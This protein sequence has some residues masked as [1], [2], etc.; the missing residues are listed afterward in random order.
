MTRTHN[1]QTETLTKNIRICKHKITSS[2]RTALVQWQAASSEDIEHCKPCLE[3]HLTAYAR[4]IDCSDS[5]FDIFRVYSRAKDFFSLLDVPLLP[6]QYSS[7]NLGVY[8]RAIGF[9]KIAVRVTL[10]GAKR[11]S[12][13]RCRLRSCNRSSSKTFLEVL[14]I[15]TNSFTTSWSL[16]KC[17]P[18]SRYSHSHSSVIMDMIDVCERLFKVLTD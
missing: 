2:L 12:D 17:F 16:Q 13:F 4:Y 10:A 14:V 18:T 8:M 11:Q 9:R 6:E 1:K 7:P 5:D 15:P 3:L